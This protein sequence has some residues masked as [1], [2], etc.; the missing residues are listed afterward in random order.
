MESTLSAGGFWSSASPNASVSFLGEVTG[1]AA[2]TVVITY[3]YGSGCARMKTMTVNPLPAVSAGDN[4]VCVG[5]MTTLTNSSAG[6]TWLSNS[7]AHATVDNA[8]GMVTGVSGGMVLMSY[9]LPTGCQRVKTMSV[10]ATPAAISGVTET[11]DGTTTVLNNTTPGGIWTSSN[12][13]VALAD[14]AGGII[15]G[16]MPGTATVNYTLSTGCKSSTTVTIHNNPAA[17]SGSTN[18]CTG[19]S[20]V[21]TN[22]TLGGVWS[23]ADDAVA[24]VSGAGVLSGV[25][26]G[27]TT[28]TYQLTTTGCYRTASVAVNALPDMK[29]VTGGGSY[30]A[31]GAGVGIGLDAS[32]TATSYKL[33]RAG[34]GLVGSYT[35]TGTPMYFGMMTTAGMYT[36]AATNASGC[37]SAMA[38]SATIAITPVVVPMVSIS[39]DLGDTVCAGQA[40]TFGTTISNGGTTPTYEWK[41][42]GVTMSGTGSS[43]AHS[44]AMGDIISVNMT[45]NAACALPAMASAVKAPIVMSVET[46]SAN[47]GVSPSASVCEGTV[48]MFTAT[49][50]NGGSTPTYTWMK[51]GSIPMGGGATLTYTPADN[52]VIT[53]RMNSSYR[54]VS[55]NNVMSNNITMNVDKVYVPEVQVIATPGTTIQ[56]GDQ[57][58]FTTNVLNAGPTPQYRWLKNGL[59]IAGANGTTYVGSNFVNGDSVTCVVKGSGACGEETINSVMLTVVPSTGVA[60]TANVTAEVKLVPNPNNGVFTVSGTIGEGSEEV[61]LEVTDMLGQ[62]V[63]RGTAQ[64]TGGKLNAGVSLGGNLANGMYLLNLHTSTSNASL[65]FVVK[66]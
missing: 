43:F 13:S 16:M 29:N 12:T 10:N 54:C 59:P 41:V 5:S 2:G 62:V 35:G 3:M 52:D 36:V 45:S 42:N 61:S 8:S 53:V 4:A 28:V 33:Y 57:V 46:P 49:A 7:P 64:V 11:C 56:Q 31:G 19:N 27:N 32:Q 34:T 20:A 38:G 22:A 50:V 39:S 26:A 47:I 37:T 51:N 40:V 44:P 18:L 24:M 58:T 1:T 55:V 66:Q 30:C 63:Y 21:L 14:I 6:G 25:A 15:T 23:S 60:Q 9:V 48:V 65:H 17:I